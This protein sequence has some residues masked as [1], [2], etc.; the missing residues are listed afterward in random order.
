MPGVMQDD[1]RCRTAALIV[2]KKDQASIR[3]ES[4]QEAARPG[5]ADAGLS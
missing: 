1:E 4:L 3:L 5:S 2:Q